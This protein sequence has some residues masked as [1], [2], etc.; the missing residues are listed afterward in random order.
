MADQSPKNIDNLRHSTAHLLAAAVMELWPKTKRAIGPSIKDGFYYDFDFGSSKI[1][2]NDFPKIEKKM[3]KL[4]PTWKKFEKK[5]LSAKEAKGEYLKNPYKHE[6]IDEFSDNGKKKISFYKSGNYADLCRGGHVDNPAKDLKH[7]KLLSVAGAYWRGNEKNKMLTRIYGTAWPTK[8]ELDKY[9]WQL[10]EAKK[11]DHRKLGQKLELFRFENIAPGA[12]FWYP[13]GMIIIKELEKLWRNVH[14]QNGYQEISTPIMTKSE[15]FKTSGHFEHYEHNMFNMEIE[16][17]QYSLKP[18]NCPEST[19][20]YASTTRSYKDLP[21]RFSEIGRLHRR[22][23]SGEL[24]GLFRVRQITMDD[25]HIYTSV[26]KMSQEIQSVIDLVKHFYGI[27]DFK[28]KFY[29]STR[30]QK[31]M[32]DKKLWDQAEIRLSQALKTKKIKYQ[33]K[34][35]EGAFYGPK[36]DVDIKDSIGRSWQLATIQLDFQMPNRFKLKYIDKDGLEREPIM[37]HRAIFGSFER[38]IGILIEHFAGAFPLWLSP[39][40]VII[41]PIGENHHLYAQKVADSLTKANVRAQVD[42]SSLSM[43][44]RIRNAEI[45]KTPYIL[46]V[47]DR[48]AKSDLVNLRT[49]GKKET[50]NVTVKKLIQKL[51]DEIESKTIM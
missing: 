40:Q 26:D 22:E 28:P 30:P 31:Y 20:V 43:Q 3:R 25:A 12:P 41:I 19:Y 10:E 17:E 13:N 51:A 18:M 49:R 27:F 9:L 32:G 2:E 37:I 33:K 8:D 23:K 38:F 24:G 15:V 35:G 6:L 39:V 5:L 1:S 7:F 45:Q 34:P 44:K 48:E 4:L 21:L 16:D 29:L 42:S 11:R 36:I 46:I 14:E 50:T 47:G